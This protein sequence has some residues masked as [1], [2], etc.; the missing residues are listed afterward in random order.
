MMRVLLSAFCFL[1]WSLTP[2]ISAAAT[3]DAAAPNGFN[4]STKTKSLGSPVIGRSTTPPA[5]AA[6]A[7]ASILNLP[8]SSLAAAPAPTNRPIVVNF[9][10]TP[11]GWFTNEAMRLTKTSTG[12]NAGWVW[13][14]NIVIT[15]RLKWPEFTNYLVTLTIGTNR[16]QAF[17]NFQGE[18]ALTNRGPVTFSVSPTNQHLITLW[19]LAADRQLRYLDQAAFPSAPS[20]VV[21][22][23]ILPLFAERLETPEALWQPGSN[24][25]SLSVTNPTGGNQFMR[26]SVRVV[27]DDFTPKAVTLGNT[28]QLFPTNP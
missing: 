15:P 14:T 11:T 13:D 20:N 18:F 5:P 16:S 7:P 22:F 25:F 3:K 9:T 4:Q 19:G 17:T 26:A 27:K 10:A 12:T 28:Y 8:S 1:L 24:I 6:A 21:T 2:G 23:L